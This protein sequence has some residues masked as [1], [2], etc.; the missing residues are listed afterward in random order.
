AM[1]KGVVEVEEKINRLTQIKQQDESVLIYTYRYEMEVAPIRHAIRDYE[2]MFW[3]IFGLK[4]SY[5]W[6][7]EMMCPMTYEEAKNFALIVEAGDD[8]ENVRENEEVKLGV[9]ELED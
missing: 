9:S 6:E 3:F 8:Q 2:E 1:I 7:V 4:E 5:R